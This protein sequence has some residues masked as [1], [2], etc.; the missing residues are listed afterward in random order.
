[1]TKLKRILAGSLALCMAGSMLTACGGDDSSKSDS[2]AADNASKAGGN[3]ATPVDDADIPAADSLVNTGKKY[4]IYVW[5]T[6]FKERFE[7]YYWPNRDEALWDGVEVNWVTNS[8]EGNVYQT[9]LDEAIS[10]QNDAKDDDKID[11]FLVEADYALKYVDSDIC[12]DVRKEVGISESDTANQYKYTQDVM[13]DS[14]GILKGLSWQ[15]T[16]GL[17][18]YNADYAKDVLGTDDPEEVQAMLSDWDKFNDVAAKMQEKGIAMVS[19][20]DDTYRCFSNTVSS[21]WVTD[22]KI[23][24]DPQISAWVDQTKDYTDKGY[25]NKTSLWDDA[26][27][28]GQKIDGKTFGY[29]FST[30]GIPF[31]LLPNTLDKSVDDGGKEE[32]GNGGY[33]KWRACAG[34]Q[35]YFWGGTWI[36]GAYGSDNI[37]ITRDI[38]LKLT[39]DTDIMKKITEEQQDY[40]NNKEAIKQ[41]IDGGYSNAFLGGQDHLSLL[42]EAADN[43]DLSNKLSAYDQGCNEQFQAAMKDYFLGNVTYDEALE[44]FKKNITNVY[45]TLT[46]D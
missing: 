33:G 9:K 26:W 35:A 43:I 24:I 27:K 32:E 34:P 14:N 5:N 46:M 16:P 18:L 7:T 28:A 10:G 31:T 42:T 20:F 41:L 23:T 15:A 19:G 3:T 30:W 38:M 11:M 17:F 44:N 8:N 40:T 29:F 25:N 13:T 45:S 22:G 21:P 2:K 39:C 6:E 36:C 12:L 37:A 1:M 4:N